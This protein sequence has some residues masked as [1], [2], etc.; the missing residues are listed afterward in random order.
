VSGDKKKRSKR[1]VERSTVEGESGH[2]LKK[3]PDTG[4]S[5]FYAGALIYL[6]SSVVY[7]IAR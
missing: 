3:S 6:A 2:P 1:E 7:I 4:Y 5:C